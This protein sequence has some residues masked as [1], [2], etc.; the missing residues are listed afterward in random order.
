MRKI[1]KIVITKYAARDGK[2]YGPGDEFPVLGVRTGWL[3]RL[4][5][6]GAKIT[7]ADD[8]KPTKMAKSEPEVNK[9]KARPKAKVDKEL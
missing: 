7:Y 9:P 4:I 3:K 2:E 5:Q 8:P 6:G 1:A